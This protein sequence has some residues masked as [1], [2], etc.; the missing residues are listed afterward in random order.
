MSGPSFTRP[1]LCSINVPTEQA[2]FGDEVCAL[3]S[4]DGYP[5]PGDDLLAPPARDVG[6]TL[7][8]AGFTLH[9][10]DRYDPVHRLHGV[11]LVPIPAESDT[12]PSANAVSPATRDL[13][14]DRNWRA[15]CRRTCQVNAEPGSVPNASKYLDRQRGTAGTCLVT[16]HRGQRT[17]AGR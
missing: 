6:R 16:C 12:H 8:E 15:T 14:L 17:E 9:H 2:E 4:G 3:F 5:L 10:R 7:V 11:C 13:L 1:D